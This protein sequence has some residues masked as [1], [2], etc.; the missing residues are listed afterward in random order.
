MVSVLVPVY[1]TKREWL[2]ECFNSI[3]QQ[4]Y[5][6]FEIVVVNDCSTNQDTLEF[7][8][9]I[10]DKENINI[11]DLEENCGLPVAL[12]VGLS[13]CKYE[14]VARMDS[15]DIMLPYRL[16]KQMNYLLKNPKVDL[17]SA[18]VNYLTEDRQ[19]WNIT[20]L[21]IHPPIIT[22]E[23]AKYSDW[24]IN[25]PTVIYKKSKIL[26]I[27]GYNEKLRGFPE[28]FDLWIRMIKCNMVLHNLQES[29]LLLRI[30][31]N[32]LSKTNNTIDF[33]QNL[34]NTL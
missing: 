8:E 5:K 32:T 31:S 16:E 20:N 29:L 15:D 25:H 26:A 23:V 28:D 27:G 30:S 34:R 2:E 33:F 21:I 9:S 19:H 22:R 10:E 6:D 3:Y 4:T 11:I 7:L 17:L 1:N 18:G 13:E 24:F 12:N 14:Y